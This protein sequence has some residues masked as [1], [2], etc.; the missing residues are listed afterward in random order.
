MIY[1]PMPGNLQ[2]LAASAGEGQ[3]T[4]LYAAAGLASRFPAEGLGNFHLRKI[5]Y[6]SA[7]S[8]DEMHM[9]FGISIKALYALNG[10]QTDD[11]PLLLKQSQVPVH[12]TYGQI[13]DLLL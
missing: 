9:G 1:F 5:I 6:P 13:R 10:S 2:T 8:A 12:R 11:F 4:A 3:L 7:G